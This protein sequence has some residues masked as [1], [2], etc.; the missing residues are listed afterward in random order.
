[1]LF[2]IALYDCSFLIAILY[3]KYTCSLFSAD[4]SDLSPLVLASDVYK[5]S[6][7]IRSYDEFVQFRKENGK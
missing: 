1:M 5:A 7:Y 3:V 6:D 4:T 2:I